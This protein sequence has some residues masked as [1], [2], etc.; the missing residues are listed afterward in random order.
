MDI[1]Q[2]GTVEILWAGLYSEIG[3]CKE[4]AENIDFFKS[5]NPTVGVGNRVPF[6][7]SKLWGRLGR[8]RSETTCLEFGPFAVDAGWQ[9]G[10]GCSHRKCP[11]LNPEP[12]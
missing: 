5:N 7:A 9:I 10:G 11:S 8:G 3:R 6:Q 4:G 1:L 2:L 12:D